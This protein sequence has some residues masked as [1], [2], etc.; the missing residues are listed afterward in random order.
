MKSVLRNI[1]I[2]S[3]K[4]NL[5]SDLVR[6]KPVSEAL[7]ILKFLPKKS[8]KPLMQAI[9]S[10]AANATQNYK[11]K[12]ESLVIDRIVVTEG[13]TL[14]RF[15]PVSRGRSHPI[16]KRTTHIRVEVAVKTPEKKESNP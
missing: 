4:V 7:S 2:S 8:A 14:K 15:R 3:K 9:Q 1:R 13:P 6:R 16:R 12:R 5:V 10:A 11:Q